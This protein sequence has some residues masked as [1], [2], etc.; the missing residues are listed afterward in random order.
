MS[1]V[2]KINI[3]ILGWLYLLSHFNS[4]KTLALI[5]LNQLQHFQ[6]AGLESL[7]NVGSSLFDWGCQDDFARVLLHLLE[8]EDKRVTPPLCFTDFSPRGPPKGSEFK[9]VLC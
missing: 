2:K 3:K 6:Q 1:G 7:G 4:I 9:G 8:K 5:D